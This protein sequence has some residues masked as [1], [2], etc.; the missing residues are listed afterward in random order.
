MN[1]AVATAA[2]DECHPTGDDSDFEL[3][4]GQTGD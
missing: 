3:L 4:L 2:I 1:F